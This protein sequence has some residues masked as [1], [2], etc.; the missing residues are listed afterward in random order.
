MSRLKKYLVILILLQTAN[1]A[2][3]R[4]WTLTPN[5]S[6]TAAQAALKA[7]NGDTLLFQKGVHRIENLQIFKTLT[8]LGEKEAVLD[9]EKK[10]YIV[11]DRKSVV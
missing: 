2:I 1:L 6:P 11:R 8:L 9:G 4:V 5:G 7:Q 3:A 10:S